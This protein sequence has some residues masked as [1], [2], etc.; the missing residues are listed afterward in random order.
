M[1]IPSAVLD[2]CFI[3]PILKYKWPDSV[4]LNKELR[5]YI[6]ELEKG[7]EKTE[8]KYSN[9]GGWHSDINV[10]NLDL[11]P[12]KILINRFRLLIDEMIKRT[13]LVNEDKWGI[14]YDIQAWANI[15]RKGNYNMPHVHQS[16]L[17]AIYYI[18]FDYETHIK[19]RSGV[20]E[21]LDPRP[22]AFMVNSPGSF[23]SNRYFVHPEPS[24]MVIFPG[25]LLHFVHPYEGEKERIS[26][27][28][29]I[30]F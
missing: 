26:I 14:N 29:D 6:L 3:T 13:T 20:L 12:F 8:G 17:A 18:S 5:E 2:N 25:Y 19:S 11:K 7:S 10:Q 22:S 9:I 30:H 28:C 16:S 24:L 23:F 1:S 15:N 4:G 27:A 21:I